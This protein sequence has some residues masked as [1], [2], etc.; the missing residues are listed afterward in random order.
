MAIYLEDCEGA[1]RPSA[2]RA[3]FLTMELEASV[4]MASVVVSWYDT[5]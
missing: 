3:F 4:I 2:F 5:R 1:L